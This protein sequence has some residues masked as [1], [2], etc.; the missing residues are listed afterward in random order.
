[1]VTI[2]QLIQYLRNNG[3]VGK[4]NPITAT[5]LANYFGISDRGVEVEMRNVIREAIAHNELIGSN[6]R[7]FYLVGT[8][9]ELEENLDSLQSRAENILQRR[10][11]MMNTWNTQNPTNQTTK[12]DLFVQ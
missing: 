3:N 1:M 5:D 10:R 4:N 7:G 8:L 12:T 9:S 6:S 2:Q 11:N